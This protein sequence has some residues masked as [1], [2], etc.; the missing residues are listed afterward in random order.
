M[1]RM[2]IRPEPSVTEALAAPDAA[3]FAAGIA[4]DCRFESE[5]KTEFSWR[6]PVR[7]STRP[8]SWPAAAAPEEGQRDSSDAG[9]A[10]ADPNR[11]PP[12]RD[13]AAGAANTSLRPA[14]PE[15]R[16]ARARLAPGA[17]G[18]V[19]GGRRGSRPGR[20]QISPPAAAPAT[21]SATSAANSGTAESFT[22]SA[23]PSFQV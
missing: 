23:K 21:S 17:L 5:N 12:P 2:S 1:A 14:A 16:S 10:A 22:Q 8:P 7:L 15:Q 4:S 3:G 11:S 13:E 18:T 9:A 19:G 20:E 6:C